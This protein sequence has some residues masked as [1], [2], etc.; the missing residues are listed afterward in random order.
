M[1]VVGVLTCVAVAGLGC[2]A[3]SHADV[4]VKLRDGRMTIEATNVSIAEILDRV[5]KNTGMKVIYDGPP[6]TQNVKVSLTERT[7]ADAV[8]GILEGRGLNFAVILNTAGTQVQT[9]LVSTVK[10]H[11][12]TRTFVPENG[13]P[14][15]PMPDG[16]EPP[17]GFVGSEENA[18]P[19]PPPPTIAAP[20]EATTAPATPVPSTLAT[21]IPPAVSPFTPQGAGPILLP[22]IPGVTP[23]PSS[24]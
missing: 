6:P 10:T 16:A 3:A 2:P 9:L 24:P 4:Q 18:I 21:P 20:P 13:P 14:E 12:R 7:P 8:L 23:I 11:I 5:A 19:A 22:G 1:R 15:L 17:M